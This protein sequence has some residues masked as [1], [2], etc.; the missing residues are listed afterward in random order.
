MRMK[1]SFA[2][3]FVVCTLLAFAQV[4][5]VQTAAAQGPDLTG[6]TPT[7]AMSGNTAVG[8]DL[9][10]K[11]NNRVFLD[12]DSQKKNAGRRGPDLTGLT[13]DPKRGTIRTSVNQSAIDQAA[14]WRW[15]TILASVGL[16]TGV[17]ALV[18]KKS[19]E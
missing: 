4:P 19:K 16:L 3:P 13:T 9:T 5:F 6:Q 10:G 8:P 14:Q 7:S 11:G 2:A 18:L 17:V 1:H 12:K 15:M